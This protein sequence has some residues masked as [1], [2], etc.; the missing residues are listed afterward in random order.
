MEARQGRKG[1]RG[2]GRSVDQTNTRKNVPRSD[3]GGNEELRTVG[4]GPGVGHGEET[5][6]SML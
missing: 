4:V 1:G 5:R 2:K 3:D 6:A